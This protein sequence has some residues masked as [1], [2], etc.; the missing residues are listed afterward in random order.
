[1]TNTTEKGGYGIEGLCADIISA[2]RLAAF[3]CEQL[4]A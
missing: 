3:L 2:L 4:E 1:M